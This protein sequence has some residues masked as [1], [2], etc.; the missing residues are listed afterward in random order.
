M[1]TWTKSKT[2]CDGPGCKKKNSLNR[3]LLE[4]NWYR[5]TTGSTDGVASESHLD[6][7]SLKCLHYAICKDQLNG[8][9]ISKPDIFEA[10]YELIDGNKGTR[11]N[12]KH[13]I[14][15]LSIL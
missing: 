15:L 11:W 1:T 10:T 12:K 4:P 9:W 13:V 7:C 8:L 6:F 5:L 14:R 3:Y 2:T